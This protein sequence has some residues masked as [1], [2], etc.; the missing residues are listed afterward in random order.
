MFGGIRRRL[1]RKILM[2]SE[3][4]ICGL[5]VVAH[6]MWARPIRQDKTRQETDQ[7]HTTSKYRVTLVKIF[8]LN[9]QLAYT[10]SDSFNLKKAALFLI[11]KLLRNSLHGL[12]FVW[13]GDEKCIIYCMHACVRSHWKFVNNFSLCVS[14]WV[15]LLL[16]LMLSN[17]MV[18]LAVGSALTAVM[19][20]L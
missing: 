14:C 1:E 12:I 16:V 8:F 10:W 13:S 19:A 18:S 7:N 11:V 6:H 15:L 2:L 17:I 5:S 3:T 20:C 4:E 9:L